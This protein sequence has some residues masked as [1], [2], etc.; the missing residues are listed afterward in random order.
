M[1]KKMEFIMRVV[2]C[3]VHSPAASFVSLSQ[4]EKQI[5]LSFKA[6]SCIM[7]L[8][9]VFLSW[10]RFS[11]CGV[12]CYEGEMGHSKIDPEGNAWITGIKRYPCSSKKERKDNYSQW[13]TNY[14]EDRRN[15]WST[16]CSWKIWIPTSSSNES[17][18][19]P[20]LDCHHRTQIPFRLQVCLPDGNII[21]ITKEWLIYG[22]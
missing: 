2:N 8:S 18:R 20:L 7:T 22:K 15:N 3:L 4:K 5:I 10:W 9:I 16:S 1:F 13:S 14:R 6:L 21:T 17:I 12:S 19:Y 11:S